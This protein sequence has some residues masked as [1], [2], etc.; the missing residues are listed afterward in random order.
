MSVDRAL[1]FAGLAASLVAL[2]WLF[3]R[4]IGPFGWDDVLKQLRDPPIL[5]GFLGLILVLASFL[6]P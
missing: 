6:L 5:L 2:V 3:G 4:M 1:A